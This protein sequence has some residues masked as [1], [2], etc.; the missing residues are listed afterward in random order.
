M[1]FC[2]IVQFRCNGKYFLKLSFCLF[3]FY[4]YVPTNSIHSYGLSLSIARFCWGTLLLL[5]I[6]YYCSVLFSPNLIIIF[7][8][9][10][11][12]LV[13][14]ILIKKKS[15]QFQICLDAYKYYFKQIFPKHKFFP[16]LCEDHTWSIAY[17]LSIHLIIM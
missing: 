9:S 4:I 11:I 14:N 7:C 5:P 16:P 8:Q 17:Y 2:V 1:R 6:V 3:L 12:I 15:F 13:P 10:H